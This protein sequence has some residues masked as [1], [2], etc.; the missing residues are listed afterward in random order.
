MGPGESVMIN[1]DV[2]GF[3]GVEKLYL[4]WDKLK[5]PGCPHSGVSRV[6]LFHVL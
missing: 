2:L 6:P 4:Q 5:C 1:R 3:S